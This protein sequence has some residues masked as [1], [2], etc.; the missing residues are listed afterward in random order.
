MTKCQC[1]SFEHLELNREVI[2]SRARVSKSIKALLEQIGEHPD[3][4]HVLYRCPVRRQNWQRSLAWNW[5]NKEYLF[6]VP[7]IDT[8]DWI[9]EPFVQPD[10]L[11]IFVA[12]I[13]R[14]IEQQRCEF[15]DLPCR[16]E[17]CPERAVTLSVFC[18]KHHI[19]SLQKIRQFPQSPAGRWFEPYNSENFAVPT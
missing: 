15:T 16:R 4:E 10:E 18:R 17:G 7:S 12:V 8:V 6:R 1:L 14:F 13:Q 19:E 3:R 2:N 11:H 9:R 5:G